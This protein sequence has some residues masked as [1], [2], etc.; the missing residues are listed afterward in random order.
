MPTDNTREGKEQERVQYKHPLQ[1][2]KISSECVILGS[3]QK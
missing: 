1:G 2:Q 3:S